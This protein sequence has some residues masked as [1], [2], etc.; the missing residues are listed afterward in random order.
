M[1]RECAKAILG[2]SNTEESILEHII[3]EQNVINMITNPTNVALSQKIQRY[4]LKEFEEVIKPIDML[5]VCD[6]AGI[7]YKEYRALYTCITACTREKGIT[8]SILPQHHTI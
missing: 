3:P 5:T 6:T 2:C 8:R 7:T 1:F 4:F